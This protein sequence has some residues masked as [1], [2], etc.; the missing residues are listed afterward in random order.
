MAPRWPTKGP[1]RLPGD[2]NGPKTAPR[3]A[4]TGPKIVQDG[5][6]MA[7]RGSRQQAMKQKG[8]KSIKN[9]QTVEEDGGFG[10]LEAVGEGVNGFK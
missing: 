3:R 2:Q 9:V 8:K 4:Q 10:G 6:K 1:R 5:A 7:S